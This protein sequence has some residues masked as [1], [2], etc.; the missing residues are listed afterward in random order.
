MYKRHLNILSLTIRVTLFI[1]LPFLLILQVI[2]QA[3]FGSPMQMNWPASLIYLGVLTSW[4]YSRYKNAIQLE[5]YKIKPDLDRILSTD[6]W[7]QVDRVGQ[8]LTVRP[9][10]D[11]PI[12]HVINDRITIDYQN[13]KFKLTGP[14]KYVTALSHSI[15]DTP[16]AKGL[17]LRSVWRVSAFVLFVLI[18]AFRASDIMWEITVLRHNREAQDNERVTATE[19]I[20]GNSVENINTGGLGIGDEDSIIYL[21]GRRD[22]VITDATFNYDQILDIDFN[23]EIGHFHLVDDWLYFTDYGTFNRIRTDGTEQEAIYDLSHTDDIH[24]INDTF[25]FINAADNYNI[26]SMNLDGQNLT[27]IARI[28]ATELTAYEDELLVTHNDGVDRISLNGSDRDVFLGEPAT[29]I[30]R[31]DGHYY[32]KGTDLNLYRKSTESPD[33]T[34]PV[35][36]R[37]IEDFTVTDESIIYTFGQDDFSHPASGLYVTD[38]QGMESEQVHASDTTGSLTKIGNSIL[39]Y[40]SDDT[41]SMDMLRFDLESG[42]IDSIYY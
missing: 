4:V 39:F 26:Y 36:E 12:N 6:R 16:P 5:D 28:R 13:E 19:T 20:S 23:N 35:I 40:A 14:L 2:Y 7:E 24:L 10:F 9:T 34:E 31:H 33:D 29:D 18:P 38:F 27:R 11:F 8:T 42:E 15:H 37:R 3:I 22:V 30:V 17:T 1:Y 25:Y 41:G 21:H 32:F